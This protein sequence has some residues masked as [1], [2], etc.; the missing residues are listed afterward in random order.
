M[1]INASPADD[2]AA[3][4]KVLFTATPVTK[5]AASVV[6]L[7]ATETAGLAR[8][9]ARVLSEMGMSIAA[10]SNATVQ[11]ATTIVDV[12][13]DK[14]NTLAA[15]KKK[16]SATVISDATM[17]ANY[18]NADIIIILGESAAPKTTTTPQ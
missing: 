14:P 10:Q 6:V 13:N 7:N 18:P 9:H 2:I 12:S 4:I 3:Q 1:S 8:T 16:Y 17:K 5:E 11:P 15:L